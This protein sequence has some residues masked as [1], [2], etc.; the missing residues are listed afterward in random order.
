MIIFVVP[1]KSRKTSKSWEYTS[2]LFG[3]CVRSLCNQTSLAFKVVVVCHEKPDINFDHPQISYIQVEFSSPELSDGHSA[4][5][6][7][8]TRKVMMGLYLAQRHRP[9]HVMIVD[10]DDC[11]SNQLAEFVSNKSRSKC[12]GWFVDNGYRYTDGKKH[13][14]VQRKLHRL[15]A[16]SI[17]IRSDLYELPE[18]LDKCTEFDTAQKYHINHNQAVE[19]MALRGTPLEPLPF[20]GSVYVSPANKDSIFSNRSF[21]RRL[22]E[23]P[24]MIFSP[25][26][27]LL[28]ETVNSQPLTDSIRKEFSL[29]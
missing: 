5:I 26:K 16:S 7:N 19:M 6:E 2:K 8:R 1:L 28:I 27:K 13:I 18:D 12:N 14:V 21:S 9:A 22:K 25:A 23:N 24:K 11:V 17:I 29:E 4:M 20:A 10:A 15:C 3:R